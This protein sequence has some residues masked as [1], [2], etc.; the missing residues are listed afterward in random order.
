MQI[1]FVTKYILDFNQYHFHTKTLLLMHKVKLRILTLTKSCGIIEDLEKLYNHCV[2]TPGQISVGAH[3]VRL[4]CLN[5]KQVTVFN[6]SSLDD[7]SVNYTLSMM[8]S[9]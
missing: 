1:Y 8:I 3:A 5:K 9:G 7:Y 4:Q 6:V 2:L